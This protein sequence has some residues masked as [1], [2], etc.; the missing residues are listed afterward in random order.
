VEGAQV[1]MPVVQQEQ[2][3]EQELVLE[4]EWVQERKS[5]SQISEQI[6]A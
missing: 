4:Q 6:S 3:L 5:A 2:G 1:L